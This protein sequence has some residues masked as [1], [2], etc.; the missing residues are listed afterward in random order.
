MDFNA[1]RNPDES[2]DTLLA[3][4]TSSSSCNEPQ[5][6]SRKTL[7]TQLLQFGWWWEIGAILV[8]IICMSLTTAVL[9]SMNGKPMRTWPLPI[10]PNSLV[11]VFSTIAKS[12]L[13]VPVAE[14][15]GQLKWDFFKR[16]RDIS[17]MQTFDEAT[18]GPWGASMLLWRTR[19]ASLLAAFGCVITVLMLAF[20]PFTQQIIEMQAQRA[21]LVNA[22]GFVSVTDNFTV[23]NLQHDLTGWLP[24]DLYLATTTGILDSISKQPASLP[25]TTYCPTLECGVE[26]FT[27]LAIC[28]FCESEKVDFG[29]DSDQCSYDI[30]EGYSLDRIKDGAYGEP[31][32]LTNQSIRGPM[33]SH[34]EFSAAVSDAEE[35]SVLLRSCATEIGS[36]AHINLTFQVTP[37]HYSPDGSSIV[38][39]GKNSNTTEELSK[40]P[41]LQ[42]MSLSWGTP[43]ENQTIGAEKVSWVTGT[44]SKPIYAL[45]D[46]QYLTKG[47]LSACVLD[48]EPRTSNSVDATPGVHP[49]NIARSTCFT[50]SSNITAMQELSHFGELSGTVTKCKPSFCA[51]RYHNVTINP[52]GMRAGRT[53]DYPFVRHTISS[54]PRAVEAQ[55]EFN[56]TFYFDPGSSPLRDLFSRTL[57]SEI[58]TYLLRT[59]LPESQDGW[60]GLF[61]RISE[62]LTQGMQSR[63]NPN[64]TKL[65]GAAYGSEV[66]IRVRWVWFVV[67]VLLVLAANGFLVA[68]ILRSRGSPFLFKNSVMAVLFHG[69]GDADTEKSGWVSGDVV[70]GSGTMRASFGRDENGHLRLRKEC[71]AYYYRH[72]RRNA[73]NSM[74]GVS[75]S[76][77]SVRRP[78]SKLPRHHAARTAERSTSPVSRRRA[79]GHCAPGSGPVCARGSHC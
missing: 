48:Q 55:D 70:G 35:N 71:A 74:Q 33:S 46:S 78:G 28:S 47:M 8:S 20:E 57:G 43:P 34:S 76:P 15:L 3:S 4:Q 45:G 41:F 25:N 53:T 58:F 7:N 63:Y 6:H 56:S 26:D 44:K 13:L 72:A 24:R 73:T 66:F 23:V 77:K 2:A 5:A 21:V 37:K 40:L 50:S 59:Q 1:I 67:P 61:G 11:A 30:Q 69:L 38:Y 68:T 9:F 54:S 52:T 75:D 65:R 36:D 42:Q 51:R 19:G 27:T 14:S 22:T 10:Q 79:P 29:K 17:H 49:L 60:E 62:V 32:F 64:A 39:M 31:Q 16:P 18:R 12:A